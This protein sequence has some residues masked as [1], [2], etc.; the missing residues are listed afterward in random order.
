MRLMFYDLAM[1]FDKS[2]SSLSGIENK[3]RIHAELRSSEIRVLK[4]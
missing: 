3:Y 4:K 2:G 1:R